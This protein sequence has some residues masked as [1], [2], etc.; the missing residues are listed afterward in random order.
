LTRTQRKFRTTRKYSYLEPADVITLELDDF[1]LVVSAQKVKISGGIMEFEAVDADAALYDPNTEGGSVGTPSELVPLLP[2]YSALMDLPPLLAADDDSGFYWAA[3]G[4]SVG[5]TGAQL[6]T[7]SDGGISYSVASATDL[8]AT[9][10]SVATALGDWPGGNFV[11]S[12]NEIAVSLYPQAS[13]LTSATLAD[14]MSSTVNAC[15]VGSE[16]NGFEVIQFKDATLVGTR[17]YVLLLS[18]A[19]WLKGRDARSK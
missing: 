3:S 17:A 5:W 7:S 16:A 14:L 9:M 2:T 13:A 6:L 4:Y 8:V 18:R 1:T 12:M 11:D 15:A 10:G 19:S